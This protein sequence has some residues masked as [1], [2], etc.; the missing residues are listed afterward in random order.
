M[1]FNR[2]I[3]LKT[4]GFQ[5][6]DLSVLVERSI[7]TAENKSIKSY[8]RGHYND[9][10]Y[11]SATNYAAASNPLHH[12]TPPNTT[13]LRRAW[14]TFQI[15]LVLEDFLTSLES[16]QPAALK[17]MSLHSK[18]KITFDNVGGLEEAKKTL[19]ETLL[20]PSKV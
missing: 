11:A 8:I 10:N 17:G 20:W 14:S 3:A 2:T 4:E 6:K 12:A 16:Y 7:S 15:P 19:K 18:G 1:Y 5:A 9:T 13:P